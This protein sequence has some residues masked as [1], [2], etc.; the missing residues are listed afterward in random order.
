MTRVL[1]AALT[2]TRNVYPHMPERLEDLRALRGQLEDIRAANVEHHL[3]LVE[4][5]ASE[6]VKLIGFGEL[7]P[8]PYFA[9]TQD[10][11]WLELAEPIDGPTVQVCQAAAKRY[12]MV[13]VAPIYEYDA[14]IDTRFNTA[15][16]IDADGEVLGHYS[17]T[18]IPHGENESNA[19]LERFYYEESSGRANPHVKNRS[20]NRYFPV[21]ETAACRLGVAICYDRHFEGVM[22]SLSREG[23]EVVLSPAA[24]FGAKSQRLWEMEFE[25]D[26][27]RHNIFIGGSNKIGS[28]P[29]W[30][31]A[32][33]GRS[34]FT[35][36]NGRCPDVS[37]HRELIIADLP[38]HE[39]A[40]GDP[41]GWQLVRHRRPDIYNRD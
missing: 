7:F 36:P 11:M 22:H 24:T 1:R 6:G 37:P 41:A 2:Q 17:K 33:Y 12:E 20:R 8:A 40:E 9:F 34:Y 29:P 10:E 27:A 23:A 16:I 5:A 38:L 3:N 15:V 14:K 26:A 39:L 25:V 4:I 31:Q 30:D 32:F 21:F 35:G 18:H 13:I 19:F 28:E